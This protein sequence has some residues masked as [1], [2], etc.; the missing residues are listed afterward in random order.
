M[1]RKFFRKYLPS[2]QSIT[3]NRWIA[4][5]RPWLGHHN[6]WHLHRRS[7]AG[8]VAIGLFA[9][10]VPGPL[11]IISGVILAILFRVNL[12]V[13]ALVTLYTNPLTIVPLYY[14]AYRY[15][16]LVTMSDAAKMPATFST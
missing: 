6:L 3:H 4:W 10:L 5:C 12:P 2:H 15:G 16:A 11:Q 14:V 1:P 13:A 8:G 7:V 9:G